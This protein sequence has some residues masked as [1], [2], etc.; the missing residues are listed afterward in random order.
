MI[1]VTAWK[2]VNC[3][4]WRWKKKMFYLDLSIIKMSQWKKGLCRWKPEMLFHI[5]CIFGAA[6]FWAN[7]SLSKTLPSWPGWSP[8][9]QTSWLDGS[10]TEDERGKSKWIY[11]NLMPRVQQASSIKKK[12]EKKENADPILVCTVLWSTLIWQWQLR[13]LFAS[14]C[15]LKKTAATWRGAHDSWAVTAT[16]DSKALA[17]SLLKTLLFPLFLLLDLFIHLGTPIQLLVTA[18]MLLLLIS[19]SRGS[20]RKV[21]F[22]I[23]AHFRRPPL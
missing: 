9:C 10:T 4:W 23:I 7:V 19:Q 20:N 1:S 5:W 18:N 16:V 15:H 6:C 14:V 8:W 21:F 22:L 2:N 17:L 13:E 11:T 12:K 3:C